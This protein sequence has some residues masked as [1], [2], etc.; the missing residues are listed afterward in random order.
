MLK[1]LGRLSGDETPIGFVTLR[2]R[3]GLWRGLTNMMSW[4]ELTIVSLID[5]GRD[6][7]PGY[8]FQVT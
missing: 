1:S 7:L 8:Q 2:G 4:E 6:Q 3:S 5:S